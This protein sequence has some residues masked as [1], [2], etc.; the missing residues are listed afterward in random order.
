[1]TTQELEELIKKADAGNWADQIAIGMIFAIGDF[2]PQDLD[3]AERW[4]KKAADQGNYW[5]I[6]FYHS[7]INRRGQPIWEPR[8]KRDA[9]Q[10][11][12]NAGDP[13]AQTEL[14]VW[15]EY[16]WGFPKDPQKA[17]AWYL[18]G[19]QQGDSYA[20]FNLGLMYSY[21]KG[22]PQNYGDA[23]K[24]FRNAAELG[25][26]ASQAGLGNLYFEGFG[27]VKN[28]EDAYF[29]YFLAADQD[30]EFAESCKKIS[31]QFTQSQR[32]KIQ[33]RCRS[34]LADFENRRIGKKR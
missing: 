27:V 17:M 14:G 26:A 12:A 7:I 6:W 30:D 3:E 34:W 16:G 20:A 5:G 15:L 32:L 4:W 19:A 10:K 22:I 9:L 13:D 18:K 29:W 11:A 8:D 1:M 21:G 25:N 24:W 33:A 28:I 23:A 2:V 31:A